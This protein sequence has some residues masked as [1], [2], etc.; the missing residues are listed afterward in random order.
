[1]SP[2]F[3]SVYASIEVFEGIYTVFNDVT[4]TMVGDYDTY[5]AA[6]AAAILIHQHYAGVSRKAGW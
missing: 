3:N 4:G 5:T 6:R 2:K 1:M